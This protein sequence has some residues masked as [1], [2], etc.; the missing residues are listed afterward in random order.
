MFLGPVL[1]SK[2]IF[3]SQAKNK[4]PM[5][6][7]SSKQKQNQNI[8][9]LTQILIFES[10]DVTESILGWVNVI[11]INILLLLIHVPLSKFVIIQKAE[12]NKI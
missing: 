5:N 11:K 8:Q 10:S 2:Y 7:W 6:F 12:G 3:R 1:T 9:K 4:A